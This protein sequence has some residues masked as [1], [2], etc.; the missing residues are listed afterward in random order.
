MKGFEH[1]RRLGLIEFRQIEKNLGLG[2]VGHGRLFKKDM[3]AGANGPNGPLEVQRVR[4]WDQDTVNIRIV[5]D[6]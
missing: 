5:E 3:F 4:Q 6:S 1:D 2:R